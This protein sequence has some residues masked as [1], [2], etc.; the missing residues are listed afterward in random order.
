ML[1]TGGRK[2][3]YGE[4]RGSLTSGSELCCICCL[5]VSSVL[6]VRACEG[7]FCSP[8]DSCHVNLHPLRGVE[9]VG[10][11]WLF[12]P[13]CTSLSRLCGAGERWRGGGKAEL[14]GAGA[15]CVSRT[16]P[17]TAQVN[18]NPPQTLNVPPSQ[19][20]HGHWPQG[21]SVWSGALARTEKAVKLT[22]VASRK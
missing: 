5:G 6:E 1:H 15:L 3:G 8:L 16:L 17:S 4:G 14:G 22:A 19:G 21:V 10:A 7:T 12:P 2:D 13:P 18:S 11:C 9:Y 20:T